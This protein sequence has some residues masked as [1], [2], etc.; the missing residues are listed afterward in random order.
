MV[1]THRD[2]GPVKDGKQER[3][4][5]YYGIRRSIL[6]GATLEVYYEL[7][8]VP[9]ATDEKPLSVS[10]E[11]MCDDMEVEDEEERTTLQKRETRWKALARDERRVKKI[12]TNMVDHFLA[13]PDPNGFKAQLV[14]IDRFACSV[15]K[16][17]LDA[18]LKA[19]GLP[20]EWSAVVISEGQNDPPELE[21]FH[22]SK[23]QTDDIIEQFK[24][25]PAQWADSN[26]KKFGNDQ[27]KWSP[28]VKILIVCDKLLTGFDAPIEQVMYL[29]KPLR[30]HNLLQALAR[31]NRPYPEMGKRNG[32]IIDYFG[33]FTNLQKALNFD[34]NVREEAVI[35][36][37]KLK[38]L[39]PDEIDRCMTFFKGIKIEDTRD[40][41]MAALRRLAD[42]EASLDFETQFK[43]TEVLWE[44]I[45]PDECLYPHRFKYAWLCSIYVAHKRRKRRAG[46]TRE[47][48]AAKTRELIQQHTTF[49]E[50]AEDVPT[51]KIGA[52]YLTKISDIKSPA[53]RAAELEAALTKELE[54]GGGGFAYKQ[55]GERLQKVID[56]KVADDA[57]AI[58]LMKD[59]EGI[60]EEVNKLKSEPDRLGLKEPGEYP[61]FTVI[62]S[63]AKTGDEAAY[64]KAA[65]T[66]IMEL[67]RG[68]HLPAG[69]SMT[70]GGRQKVSLA[71]QVASWMPGVCELGLCPEGEA[72]PAF[73]AAAVEELARTTA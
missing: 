65:K 63:M 2:F 70:G 38:A 29:D 67:R 53:D 68:H 43:R 61:I 7:R 44:A 22:L 31:T 45:S 5:S 28:P 17:Q 23:E 64:V 36:W 19:R 48:L 3:Y 46:A 14:A 72:D 73:L 37:D 71:L 21:R 32:L 30:D 6:D 9:L 8:T 20:P 27:A 51:Y 54:E 13:H 47:E 42:P 39:V 34:E 62:R 66:L 26:Q 11:Q 12:I 41:L 40:C 10:F 69:W 24:L 57:A 25:T 55:L 33:V 52:D 60:V 58:R 56:Q 18:E 50:I 1:N 15:Y 16:D 35:D 4:L 59:L 49:M